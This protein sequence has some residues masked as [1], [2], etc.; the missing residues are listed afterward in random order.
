[1]NVLLDTNVLSE[2]R[3]PAHS[4]DPNVR[5]W[6]AAQQPEGLWLSVIS[7]LEIE[8]GIAR[9]ERRDSAQ[10]RRLQVWLE[11]GVLDVFNG[12]LLSVDT[13]VAR[14][15][16]R[17]H[18]PDPRTERDVLIAAT[19]QVHGLTVATRNVRDFEPLGVSYVNPWG[20]Q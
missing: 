6:F 11:Q 2:V 17:M 16:A 7:V 10:A 4:A 14:V 1:M 18:V 15:A 3:K 8:L 5:T 9:L 13:A 12:R 19:A 20:T